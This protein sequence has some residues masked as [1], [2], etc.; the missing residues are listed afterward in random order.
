LTTLQ[1][2]LL[3]AQFSPTGQYSPTQY[4]LT[5]AYVLLVHAEVEAFLEDRSRERVKKLEK[6]W[7][8]KRRRTKGLRR[9]IQAHDSHHRQPWR[10][11]DWSNDKVNSAIMSYLSLISNNNG[12]KEKD[13]CQMLFPLGIDYEALDVTWLANMSS[14]GVARGG[15]AHSSIKTHQPIDPENEL[16]KVR[17]LLK[18]LSRIDRKL[19]GLG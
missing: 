19:S 17:Q 9:L 6:A 2:H 12:I 11:V 15:F 4:D 18:G 8:T 16:N 7:S 10:P 1:K 14:F 5:K 13:I 3:P